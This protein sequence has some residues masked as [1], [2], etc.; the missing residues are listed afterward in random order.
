MSKFEITSIKVHKLPKTENSN[1]VGIAS[2]VLNHAFLVN[3]IRI[4][5]ANDKLFCGMPSRRL[6]DK[7]FMDICHPLN[8]DVRKYLENLILAEYINADYEEDK[9][10]E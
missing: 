1:I 6:E 5:Q 3:D 2:I 10:D 9:K 8:N 4:I 7:S